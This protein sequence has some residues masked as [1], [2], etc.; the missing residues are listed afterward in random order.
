MKLVF[1]LAHFFVNF[2]N[3]HLGPRLGQ[4]CGIDKLIDINNYCLIIIIIK[5]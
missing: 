2:K 5:I 4:I 3:N 1:F